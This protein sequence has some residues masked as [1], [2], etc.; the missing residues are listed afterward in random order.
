[1]ARLRRT[2][3]HVV[4]W[5]SLLVLVL[6]A[7]AFVLIRTGPGQRFAIEKALGVLRGRIQGTLEIGAV[8][9]RS[10]LEGVILGDVR[11]ADVDGRPLLEAD[12]IAVRYSLLPLLRGDLAF[13]RVELW[14]PRVTLERLPG[15][16]TFNALRV[17]SAGG[18]G[19]AGAD[20]SSGGGGTDVVLHDL[21]LHDGRVIIRLPLGEGDTAP[22]GRV[23]EVPGGRV[24]TL[25]FTEIDASVPLV[26]I[27]G[28]DGP[29]ESAQIRSLS[30]VGGVLEEPFRL[31]D[32]RGRIWRE[33]TRISFD[34]DRLWLPTTE[35]GGSGRLDLGAPDG[36]DLSA[37]L[38]AT[39]IQLGDL[40]WLEP[41][42]PDARGAFDLHAEK[43]GGTVLLQLANLDLILQESRVRGRLGLRLGEGPLRFVDT[44]LLP[45]P[46]ALTRLAPFVGEPLPLEGQVRGRLALDGPLS[47]LR[48]GGRLSLEEPGVDGAPST[49]RIDGILHVGEGPVG[50]TE[51][52]LVLDPFRF[53]LAG[54]IDP[55]LA[56]RGP[57]SVSLTASGRYGEEIRFDARI[58]HRPSGLPHSS[59][60]LRGTVA[61][62]GDSLRLDVMSQLEPLSFTALAAYY[63]EIGVQGEATGSLQ[64]RGPL[65]D[66]DV[67]ARFATPGGV[68]PLAARLDVRDPGSRYRIE[69]DLED[70]ELST[71]L[72]SLPGPTVVTGRTLL[73]GSG[74]DLDSLQANG[75][76]DLRSSRVGHLDIDSLTTRFRIRDGTLLMDTVAA[77]TSAVAVS[78]SGTLAVAEG[79]PEGE[80]ELDLASDSLGGLRPFL[81]GDTVIARDTLSAIERNILEMEGVNPDTLPTEDAVTM[82]GRLR[83]RVVLRGSLRD[84]AARGF[85]QVEEVVYGHSFLQGA[86]LDFEAAGLPEL[87]SRIQMTLQ[88]DSVR[89]ASRS[90]MGAE[91]SLDYTRPEGDL[92][93]LV[94]RSEE[95]DYRV[96][97][98]FQADSL[99]GVVRL[100]T[101][102]L[103]FDPVRWSLAR[104]ATISW[105]QEGVTVQDFRLV[106]PGE[107]AMRIAADGRLPIRGEGDFR[108]EVDS[109]SLGRLA[110]LGQLDRQIEGNLNLRLDVRGTAASPVMDGTMEIRE[111]SY[112]S[113]GFSLVQGGIRYRDRAMT[114]GLLAWQDG[115]VALTVEGRQPIDLALQDV[116]ERLP[117]EEMD[118]RIRIDSLPAAGLLSFMDVAEDVRGILDGEVQVTGTLQDPSPSGT[119][120]LRDGGA[121]LPTLGVA[122]GRA[123]GTFELDPDGTIR[124]DAEARSGGIARVQGT[125]GLS[126]ATDPSLDLRITAQGFQA[127]DRRDVTAVVGGRMS[128]GGSY[129]RPLLEGQVTVDQGVLFLDEFARGVQVVDLSDPAFFDVVD[130]SLVAVRPLLAESQNPFLSNLRVDVDL[131]V[132]RDSWIRSPD[133]NVE[134]LGELTVVYDRT[135]KELAL[136]GELQA[137]RGSY[138][139]YG[140]RFDVQEGTVEF[141]GTPGLNPSLDI[142]AVTRL[143]RPSQEPLNIAA[144]VQG[145]LTN[146]RIELSSDAQPPIAQ[147]DL[148][149]YLIFGRPAGLLG[150]GERSVAGGAGQLLGGIASAGASLGLG[151]LTAQLSSAVAQEIG[152]FDYFAIT[153]NEQPDAAVGPN[154]LA[155]TF[156]QSL[157][158]AQVELG[159]YFFEDV[160]VAVLL[161]PLTGLTGTERVSRPGVR[162]E[163]RFSDLWTVEGFVEDRFAR[164]GAT[165]FGDLGFRPEQVLGLSLFREWGY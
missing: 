41:R 8:R 74:L 69:A 139:A 151:T 28:D 13:G 159:R 17:F 19:A 70:F 77:R 44:E 2:L 18:D 26:R 162:V 47:S 150:P 155:Q 109:L 67:R 56:L 31:R 72:P 106:R 62:A 49:A 76:L 79:V 135:E 137:V 52:S 107:S 22:E 153:T 58:A 114:V 99:G 111:L 95:E 134:L 36:L 148:V 23:E 101:L 149:S 84:F 61:G 93:L 143:R 127:V 126:P 48:V 97:A 117:N 3:A 89:L 82:D 9:S 157:A 88:A 121:R 165:G 43:R 6:G 116:E 160:F 90:F 21:V 24:R 86:R 115:S 122:F 136:V 164:S 40:R 156:T 7:L 39:V 68:L 110:R 46:L 65:E 78:G 85:L 104:T 147:A 132:E 144:M 4:L 55:R 158:S 27:G 29:D 118:L 140:R 59:V 42:L 57:G 30:L 87:G 45:Q 123:R 94:R 38:E 53:E 130:T 25:A 92:D 154:P 141:V 32:F 124:V 98:A 119:V 128:L 50:V 102:A 161:R 54:R 133:M 71:V 63:P 100:D 131:V 51:L 73:V 1:M 145:T 11:V 60:R 66:L 138:N 10:L 83:G 64:L 80:L 120:R 142:R 113:I 15:Q 5:G 129:R 20:T 125:I 12:S 152:F 75:E 35:L 33:G 37:D 96:R 105:S 108:L 146:P 14:R 16:S 81:L 163:W 91:A 34:A 112:D 103:R